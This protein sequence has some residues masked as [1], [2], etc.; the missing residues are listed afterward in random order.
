GGRDHLDQIGFLFLQVLP[1]KVSPL[2][3]RSRF[4]RQEVAL[5]AL[6]LA[7]VAVVG[8]NHD[9]GANRLV[10][11]QWLNLGSQQ[12]AVVDSQV[13]K[14]AL[15]SLAQIL[16]ADLELAGRRQLPGQFVGENLHLARLAIKEDVQAGGLPQAIVV[17]DDLMPV[18]WIEPVF[19]TYLQSIRRPLTAKP[20]VE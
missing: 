4:R 17:H 18:G 12:W 2:Q 15:E 9:G 10:S 11:E 20:Y 7:I 5:E 14:L 3:F 1:R 19:R 13:V 16:V 6:L 8:W